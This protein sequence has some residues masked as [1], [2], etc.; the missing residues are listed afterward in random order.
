V[1]GL[2]LTMI[3]QSPMRDALASFLELRAGPGFSSSASPSID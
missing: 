1:S 2:N 3:R